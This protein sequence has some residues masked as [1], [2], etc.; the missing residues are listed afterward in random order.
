MLSVDLLEVCIFKENKLSE[1]DYELAAKYRLM[2]KNKINEIV[3]KLKSL[4]IIE[5][6][7]LTLNFD[8]SDMKNDAT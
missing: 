3:Q 5:R 2:E 7:I 1:G 4:K 8:F 6:D